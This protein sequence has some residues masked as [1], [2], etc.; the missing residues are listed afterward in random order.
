[1]IK[2]NEINQ[3]ANEVLATLRKCKPVTNENVIQL[4]ELIIAINNC[5]ESGGGLNALI[6]NWEDRL[7]IQ[8]LLVFHNNSIWRNDCEEVTGEPGVDECWTLLAEINQKL[9][10]ENIEGDQS[11]VN[12]SEF[13]NDAEFITLDDVPISK[14]EYDIFTDVT[15]GGVVEGD[16]LEEGMSLTQVIEAIFSKTFYPT[17]TSPAF[18]LSHNQTSGGGL[19]EV[20]VSIN[21]LLTANF[22]RGQINGDVVGGVWNPSV[23]QDFRTGTVVDY[24]IAGTNTGVTNT[25]T[26]TG[27]TVISGNNTF[28]ATVNYNEGVQPLD[29]SG[30]NY[31]TPYPAGNMSANTQFTGIYPI[32]WFKSSSPISAADMQT[33]IANGDAT[34]IIVSSTGTIT[35]PFNA[36][37]E[38]LAVAYPATSTT[39]TVWWVNALDNG[40][41]P[42]GVFGAFTQL[43][44]SSPTG[45]WSGINY[46]IH[47]SPG[48]ITQSNPIELRNS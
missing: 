15:V 27:Y 16:I 13:N 48:L 7:Y 21:V 41:I 1:M 19:R 5:N 23:A 36:T 44:C 32:F 20:G 40:A 45:L 26:I 10:W 37:G 17:F 29:S 34:K 39:K 24:I 14:L 46:K 31:M 43:P 11:T 22:N 42:G 38:Y 47:V 25:R 12:L 9:L 8:G 6:P 35:I 28:P 30:N 33:A 4:T 18:S 2:C 3:V